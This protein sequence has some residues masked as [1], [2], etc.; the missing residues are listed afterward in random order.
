MNVTEIRVVDCV[1]FENYPFKIQDN[2]DMEMLIDSLRRQPFIAGF[3]RTMKDRV[4]ACPLKRKSPCS[5]AMHRR[6]D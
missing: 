6:T 4:R 1:P 5:C 3:P 2:S